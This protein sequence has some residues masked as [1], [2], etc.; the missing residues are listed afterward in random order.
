MITYPILWSPIFFTIR[1]QTL[2]N[3]FRDISYNYFIISDYFLFLISTTLR[4]PLSLIFVIHMHQI[5]PLQILIS[6]LKG[7]TSVASLFVGVLYV[8]LW[9]QKY[10]YKKYFNRRGSYFSVFRMGF[11]LVCTSLLKK[12]S[13]RFHNKVKFNLLWFKK[14]R[15][16]HA[17]ILGYTI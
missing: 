4:N 6:W 8:I 15:I 14:F 11:K 17:S 5:Q 16:S 12:L 10:I 13:S 7:S 9:R 1:F 3:I 2:D